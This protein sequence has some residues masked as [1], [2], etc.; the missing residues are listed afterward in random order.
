MS[1]CGCV[2]VD[3]LTS[4]KE[5]AN[6]F[7]SDFSNKWMLDHDF[8]NNLDT[9]QLL[10]DKEGIPSLLHCGSLCNSN[11][12]CRSFFYHPSLM[13]CLGSQ[14]YKRG[15]PSGQSMQLGW[16][17][18]TKSQQCDG[19]Y[20][21]NKTLELCFKIHPETKTYEEAMKT[22]EAEGAKLIIIRNKME[23]DY[24]IDVLKAAGPLTYALNG[25]RKIIS[26][27]IIT[28]KWWSGKIPSYMEWEPGEPDNF[29]QDEYCGN[30][31][32]V[33]GYQ[34]KFDDINCGWKSSFV[35]Q[36]YI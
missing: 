4:F 34:Y 28:W 3:I 13:K 7:P 25:L 1:T 17:Y 26:N 24:I 31:F 12:S 27:G 22:C 36:K 16:K 23:F 6:H 29:L 11:T 20:T 19:N 10:W 9:S 15:L 2:V 35:C 21:F 5:F 32:A 33:P 30:F 18:Y 8:E 14:S